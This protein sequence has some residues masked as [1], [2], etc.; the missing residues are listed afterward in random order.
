[1]SHTFTELDGQGLQDRVTNAAKR[2]VV[3][4]ARGYIGTPWVHQGRLKGKSIDCLGLLVCVAREFGAE[5]KLDRTDYDNRK[6]DTA[7][8]RKVLEH[9][10]E[11]KPISKAAPGDVLLFALGGSPQHL[12]IKTDKG[13]IHANMRTRWVKEDSMDKFIKKDIVACFD[14]RPWDWIGKE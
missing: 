5:V 13:M 12:A 11:E 4:C 3:R 10:M 14:F 1:M 8:M 6:I 7:A 9:Y 2:S